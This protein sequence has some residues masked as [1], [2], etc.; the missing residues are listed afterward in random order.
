MKYVGLIITLLFLLA[1]PAHMP[2]FGGK[3]FMG[4]SERSGIARNNPNEPA[5]FIP[6]NDPTFDSYVCTR[7]VDLANYLAQVEKAL[8]SCK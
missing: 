1:C 7:A 5:E 8:H 4:D 3:L 2:V 6:A